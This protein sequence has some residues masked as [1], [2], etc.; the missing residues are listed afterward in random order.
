MV[1]FISLLAISYPNDPPPARADLII[2]HAN[3]ISAPDADFV[4]GASIVIS[5]GRI[6][7]IQKPSET[8]EWDA[9]V[10][11]DATGLTVMAG[12]WNCHVHFTEPIWNEAASQDDAGLAQALAD[13]FLKFGFVNVIDTGS[14]PSITREIRHRI[15]SGDIAGPQIQMM[16]GSFVAKDGTPV[17][18]PV[19]LPELVNQA[20]AKALTRTTLDGG[21]DGIKL[22]TGSLLGSDQRAHLP[23]DLI[24]SVTDQ[25][26]ALGKPVFAHPQT[27]TGVTRA[28]QGGVDV[29]AHTAPEAGAWSAALVHEMV[30]REVALVPTLQLWRWE[31][32]RAGLPETLISRYENIATAQLGSLLKAGGQVLFGT[33]VGYM[34]AFDPTDEF[35]LMAR[36]MT[37]REI[38][39]ALTLNP[40][41]R[42]AGKGSGTVAVGQ[43][44]DLVMVAGNPLA[45]V[46]QFAQVSHTI[47]SGSIVYQH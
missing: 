28:V 30:D 44:A 38:L 47:R 32:G 29:L 21:A 13:R 43:P 20:Q 10:T 15:E 35:R 19:K 16:S 46:E 1:L 36:V 25:A 2:V 26:H 3:L 37:A 11:I 27:L 14:L 8:R 9:E 42:F 6:I 22:F 12:Y 33:D 17:Y 45:N 34:T 5:N 18:V 4:N 40:A 7:A 31:L 23:L 24:R 41:Q 39:A